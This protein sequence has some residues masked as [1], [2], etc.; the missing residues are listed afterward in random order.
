MRYNPVTGLIGNGST[1]PK[2]SMASQ[3]AASLAANPD[4]S[5][6]GY[7][8]AGSIFG[9][10]P[11]PGTPSMSSDGFSGSFGSGGNTLTTADWQK[12]IA[13]DAGLQSA[14]AAL[15]GSQAADQNALGAEIKNA[16][17]GFGKPV[18]LA[19]LASQLG[20]NQADIQNYLGSDAQKIAQENTDA[21]TSTTARLDQANQNATRGIVA[22]LNKRGM[23]YSGD[24]GHQLDQQNLGYRQAQQDAYSKFLG[25]L[26]QYQQ[27]YLTAQQQRAAALAAA[28][29]SAA[30]RQLSLN[31]S[32]PG[33]ASGGGGAGGS[34]TGGSG[35]GGSG[36]GGG[37]AAFPAPIPAPKLTPIA[38][39]DLNRILSNVHRPGAQLDYGV[40]ATPS[41]PIPLPALSPIPT[42][43]L[44]RLLS[45]VHRPGVQLEG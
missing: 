40:P 28:I 30:D 26:Q 4:A 27:G 13:G 39:S 9:G 29:N 34:T 20:M 22:G 14:E 3:I 41:H 8:I 31:Q 32:L 21:G 10:T 33:G 25:Y 43:E 45:N 23:L 35:G 7:G 42:A 11:I 37:S 6:G 15:S 36:G 19:T 1:T 18:D 44:R 17:E 5:L 38:P 2:G 12:L 24:T 16:Y